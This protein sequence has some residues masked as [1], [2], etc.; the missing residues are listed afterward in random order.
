[1]LPR[2][3]EDASSSLRLATVRKRW[4]AGSDQL[5]TVPGAGRDSNAER[6]PGSGSLGAP[7]FAMYKH[8]DCNI[9]QT[10]EESRARPL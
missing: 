3:A 5:I 2:L 7:G 10:L 1:M 9:E 4:E 8:P 6:N